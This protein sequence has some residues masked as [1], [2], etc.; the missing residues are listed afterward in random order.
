MI[1]EGA[2]PLN[3]N[4]ALSSD[5]GYV[6]V[7]NGKPGTGKSLFVQ[8]VFRNFDKSFMILTNTESSSILCNELNAS[9]ANWNERHI[10][11]QYWRSINEETFYDSSLQKQI[12]ELVGNFPDISNTE[13]I[14]IDSWTNFIEPIEKERRYEIQQ[15]LICWTRK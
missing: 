9:I 10:Y 12:S 13:I 7:V 1:S 3:V 4:N 6:I 8:Q 5:T 11:A 15:S 2:I 14:I